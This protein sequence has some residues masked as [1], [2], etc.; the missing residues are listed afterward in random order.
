[1]KTKRQF[2]VQPYA[3]IDWRRRDPGSEI[4]IRG[5]WLTRAGFPPGTSVLLTV[6][7]PGVVEIRLNAPRAALGETFGGTLAGVV[8]KLG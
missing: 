7:S 5:K 8:D 3:P 2:A 4:Q 6:I 1:M